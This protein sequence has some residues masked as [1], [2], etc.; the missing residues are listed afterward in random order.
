MTRPGSAKIQ[1]KLDSI[2]LDTELSPRRFHGILKS[3][4]ALLAGGSVLY[5]LLA[6]NDD[7]TPRPKDFDI[8]VSV[9]NAKKLLSEIKPYIHNVYT[10][11][12]PSY[13][14]SFMRNNGI[15]ARCHGGM[16]MKP[17]H[18]S[19]YVDIMIVDKDVHDVVKNF[20]LTC[21]QVWW[22]GDKYDGTHIEIT[23]NKEAFLRKSY[24]ETFI[25]TFNY[26][27][28]N[29]L[30]KYTKRG[31]TIIYEEYEKC[32]SNEFDYRTKRTISSLE[33][34]AIKKTLELVKCDAITIICEIYESGKNPFNLNDFIN[35]M[36]I[37][38]Q[39]YKF[40]E[41]VNAHLENFL[42][43]TESFKSR[44]ANVTDLHVYIK[45]NILDVE[46]FKLNDN[47]TIHST[48][49]YRGQAMG[50]EAEQLAQ[51]TGPHKPYF[52]IMGFKDIN[53]NNDMIQFLNDNRINESDMFIFTFKNDSICISPTYL[54]SF[55][56]EIENNWYFE[57]NT[58]NLDKNNNKYYLN[59][60]YIRLPLSKDKDK[61]ILVPLQQLM[62]IYDTSSR[63]FVLEMN[64]KEL[65]R[66][67]IGK[68]VLPNRSPYY[69]WGDHC[70][71]GAE[72]TICNLLL[73]TI[74]TIN[75]NG[76][77]KKKRTKNNPK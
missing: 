11:T 7:N 21:C 60:P 64:K 17:G 68:Y 46:K 52:D 16:K 40:F 53:D 43:D 23:L 27:T 39:R 71:D 49:K 45:K 6:N 34:W 32:N 20:D 62:S 3:N 58:D 75:T 44:S 10:H 69:F 51:V 77:G 28:M 72:Y 38:Q 13:D 14:E 55:I 31:F 54:E 74:N 2:L 18:K 66:L 9:N 36:T 4:Q 29:R 50:Y 70:Q 19:L 48:I 73:N 37:N 47:N 63:S 76:G 5:A 56:Q 59:K 41:V 24:V 42:K 61:K 35:Y 12:A 8:Y 1:S 67:A 22:D 33:E 26:F 57:C 25:R 15:V 65:K 30:N